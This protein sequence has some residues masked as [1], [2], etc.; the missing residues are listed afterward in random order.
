VNGDSKLAFDNW[1]KG[2]YEILSR[3]CATVIAKRWVGTE[4]KEHPKYNGTLD[5]GTFLV[6]MEENIAE[7]QRI[8]VLDLALE[9]TPARW[10]A[11]H[12]E[13]IRNWEDVKHAI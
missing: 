7:D 6:S 8:V 5:L 11:S 1:K 12:K 3:H 4:V 9:D 13:I 2:T 10:W